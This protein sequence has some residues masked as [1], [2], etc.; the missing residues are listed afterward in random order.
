MALDTACSSSLVAVHLA[1][2][3]LHSRESDLVLAGGVNLIL[4]PE[5]TIAASK[6]GMLSADGRCKTFDARADGFVR[7][8]GCGIVVLKRLSDALAAGDRIHALIRGSA[9]N[10]DGFKSGFTVPNKLAQEAVIRSALATAQV[11]PGQVGYVEAHGTGTSLGDPIEVRA[12]AAVFGNDRPKDHP[13]MLGSVKTNLGH[14]EAASGVTGLIKVVLS[15]Q[16]R[17]IP[18]HLHLRE[19]NPHIEWDEMPLVV[20]TE[21]TPWPAGSEPRYAGVSSFGASGVNAH[22]VLE[23]APTAPQNAGAELAPDQAYLLPLSAH[24][25]AALE[26]LGRAYQHFLRQGPADARLADVC[27][28]ASVRR[29]HFDH[30]LAVVGQ[31]RE[32]LSAQ[33]DRYLRGE[34]GPGVAAGWREPGR[35]AKL[36]FVFSG[37]GPQW[38]AMGRELLEHEPVFRESVERCDAL[39]RARAGWSLLAELTASEAASRLHETEIAQPAIFALQV[40]LAALWRSWGIVPDA[41]VGHSVGEI[42]AAQVAGALTLEDAVRVV[43]HRGR[44]MQQ[45]TGRGKM[46]QVELPLEEAARAIAGYGDRLSIAALN[47]PRTTVLSG[48][49]AALA[50][51]LD[52][53]RAQGVSNRL[54]PV[55]YAFH[56]AQMAP[57]QRELA[58][59]LQGLAPQPAAIRI[60]STVSGA[61]A[62]GA[63]FDAAYWGRNVR[64]P[65]RFAPAIGALAR[66]DHS[67]FLEISPH[68]VLSGA[69]SECLA[70]G[71]YEG[72]AV[73]SLRRGRDERATLLAA[74]GELYAHGCTVAWDRLYPAAGR[75]VALPSYPWQR[76][77]YW[78]EPP[79]SG[80]RHQPARPRRAGSSSAG[81]PLLGE[82]LCSPLKAVQFEARLNTAA[83][84]L[85]NDHRAYG[86]AILP[87]MAMLEMTLSAAA[88]ALGPGPRA[89]EG[90]AIQ[91]ALVVPDDE[92]QTCQTVLTP[93][94]NGASVEIVSLAADGE[95]WARHMSAA[96]VSAAGDGEP[97]GEPIAAIQARCPQSATADEHYTAL[98]A[99]GIALG[100]S[101]Q[102]VRQ[103]WRRDGEALGHIELPAAALA[104]APAF[105]VH[106]A[107]LDAAAQLVVE[108]CPTDDTYLPVGLDRF[109][110]HRQPGTQLWGHVV[111]RPQG[112]PA[113]GK[114]VADIRLLDD[115]G[116]VL[117][118]L[119]GLA[120][121]RARPE[122][123]LRP[124]ASPQDQWR[125]EV[126]WRLL[127]RAAAP[128]A[129]REAAGAWLVFADASGV[130]DELAR[131]LAERG[132]T[133]HLVRLGPRFQAVAAGRWQINPTQ[134]A[135]VRRLLDETR[136]A[137]QPLCGVVHLCSLD[138]PADDDLPQAE[139]DAATVR[140]YGSALAVVQALAAEPTQPPPGLWLVTRGAQAAG[141]ARPLAVAQAPIWGLGQVIGLEYPDLRC[142]RLDLDPVAEARTAAAALF[143]EI[144]EPDR[145]DQ[146][147]LRDGGRYVARLTRSAARPA[148]RAASAADE[149]PVELA[150]REP[151]SLSSLALAPTARRAPGPGEVEIRVEASGLNFKD[152]LT[153]LGMLPPEAT[154]PLGLECAGVVTAIGPDVADL[155]VGDEVVAL[156]AGSF[157]TFVVRPAAL[158][159]RKPA[160]LSMTDAASAPVAF[161]TAY[162]GLHH[163]A[164]LQPGERVLIHAA[165][166]GVGQA[167]VRL[168]LRAGAEVFATVS[169]PEKRACVEAL[170]V[171]HVMHSRT[172]DFA[173]EILAATGGEGVDVVLNSLAGE[174]IPA[175]FRAL[176]ADGRFLELGKR[177]IWSAEQA[178]AARPRARY[179]PYDLVGP[180]VDEPDRLSALLRTL[181]DDLASGALQP[182]PIRAFPLAA[183]GEAFRLM[184]QAKHIGK[185][186]LTQPAA[187]PAPRSHI[188]PDAT[189]LVTGGL[190][191]L[192]LVVAEWLVEQGAR[193]LALVG[194]SAPSAAAQTV[195]DRLTA[196]GARVM[197]Q[198]AD[199]ARRDDVAQVLAAIDQ[200]M[201]PLRGVFHL[202]AVLDDGVLLQQSV[203]RFRTVSAPKAAGAWHLHALTRERALDCFV[204]FSSLSAI[205]GAPGQGNYAAANA[206][207][208][209]LAQQRH[210]RGLPALAINWGAWDAVGM[211]ADLD[212][213]DRDRLTARG[214]AP[215]AP[216]QALAALGQALQQDAPQMVITPVDWT[217]FRDGAAERERPFFADLLRDAASSS[218]PSAPAAAPPA[219]LRQWAETPPSKRRN[220][221]L[222]YLR[223]A[224]IAVLGLDASAPIAPRQPLS[225]LGLDSLMAVEL[226]NSLSKTLGCPLPATLLFD[227]PTLE[228]LADFLMTAVPGL[229]AAPAPPAEPLAAPPNGARDAAIVALDELSDDEAEALLL[230][231]L[232]R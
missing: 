204:L 104:G 93:D 176:K 232:S 139:L 110:L 3:S 186:V 127:P 92:V 112:G 51:A 213:H 160:A 210:S 100:P 95:T 142:V 38:W 228:T 52:A 77:R 97:V 201:P 11:E 16:A 190:G 217:V 56:S 24:S 55:N 1:C 212:R 152:V 89:V 6:N 131:L 91:E 48:E 88:A 101:W 58:D 13:L 80:Q 230:A 10:Q 29:T 194:R 20:P 178:A 214:L 113:T 103:L 30:R 203:D 73:A 218:E 122:T 135:D 78:F 189:Y 116:G 23:E 150:V 182:L 71:G 65:V 206:F 209:S 138:T 231:E 163:L 4:S 34:R 120:Y 177:G 105:Q 136:A 171:Q 72:H 166:G 129:R 133:C 40:A 151:G 185:L 123:L 197:V 181:L 134:P 221:L 196:A 222:G 128:A 27:Y 187:G 208:D 2:H 57:F 168:A 124:A 94:G 175:S 21:R 180:M 146:V 54:L 39:L 154:A 227:Y 32:E 179:L 193:H 82:R 137:D 37:Q 35:R 90:L 61:E 130:G 174:F 164:R 202:A 144:W 63:D 159:V 205:F 119:S 192:G 8:E 14:L 96:V 18:P 28:T 67:I 188:R 15:L 115:D 121:L 45:A 169:T 69:V 76:Q 108:A 62:G 7:S 229:A 141:P 5:W 125:Y 75:H 220:L 200:S 109:R 118:E 9:V 195:L 156:G 132:Q 191:R 70:A 66:D 19:P 81:H 31:S 140:G 74:L 148:P 17:E 149:Q 211:A 46:A 223:E 147:A 87:G 157:Q 198:R 49:P 83:L 33:L 219:L 60:Y 12:L 68:P 126:A 224:A 99:H 43:Y 165:A 145:E 161:L 106:P 199:V 173:D 215:M 50:A 207:L 22:V 36:A 47:G 59:A 183:A 143:A 26:A 155:Q 226:R 172:L 102:G 184:A 44:L 53:L 85:L 25:P 216:A 64:E 79:A 114:L 84:D 225:E 86:T 117:A 153:A 42:A 107:L 162:W 111:I 167:A 41:V 98:R 158:V 170:G